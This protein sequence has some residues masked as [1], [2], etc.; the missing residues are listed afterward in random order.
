MAGEPEIPLPVMTEYEEEALGM[1]FSCPYLWVME[2]I[3]EDGSFS[4]SFYSPYE[5]EN[6][7]DMSNM[8]LDIYGAYEGDFLQ[9]LSDSLAERGFEIQRSE[10][11]GYPMMD[12]IGMWEEPGEETFRN[13]IVMIQVADEYVGFTFYIHE[14]FGTDADEL[15]QSIVDTIEFGG[16]SQPEAEETE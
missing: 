14:D 12:A 11:N 9:E 7:W 1:T 8:Y 4:I 6:V 3:S 2:D 15:F 10:I 13:R 5:G 16:D